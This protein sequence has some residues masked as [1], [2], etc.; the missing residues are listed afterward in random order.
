MDRKDFSDEPSEEVC[1]DSVSFA[2]IDSVR[3]FLGYALKPFSGLRI[4][5]GGIARCIM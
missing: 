2:E 5:V 4:G 1:A 3:I